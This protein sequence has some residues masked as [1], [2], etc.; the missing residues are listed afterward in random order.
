MFSFQSKTRKSRFVSA[1]FDT[2]FESF[3]FRKLLVL[4]LKPPAL[5][6]RVELVEEDERVGKEKAGDGKTKS[7]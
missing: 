1:L 5:S 6:G 3:H 7:S 4:V 2:F